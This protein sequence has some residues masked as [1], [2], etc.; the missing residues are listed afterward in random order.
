MGQTG[1]SQSGDGRAVTLHQPGDDRVRGGDAD[2]LTDDGSHPGLE[3]I[4]GT[5]RRTPGAISS[6]GPMIGSPDS[7]AVASAASA[8]RLKI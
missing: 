2:Q 4:P 5:G 6:N 7:K 1:G 3:R 8:S